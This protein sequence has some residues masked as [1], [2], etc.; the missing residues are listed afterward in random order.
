M[1]TTP[2]YEIP[3]GPSR[4]E[5][6][7]LL[8]ALERYFRDERPNPAAWSLA[9]RLDATG[10]GWLQARRLA[11]APWQRSSRGPFARRGTPNLHGRG[12]SS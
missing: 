6:R 1:M 4:E 11:H 2:R 10:L 8:A 12:D 5:E 9:G 7:A 3:D